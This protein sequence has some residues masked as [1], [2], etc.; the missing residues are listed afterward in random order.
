MPQVVRRY[1]PALSAACPN[2]GCRKRRFDLR[3]QFYCQFNRY[4]GLHSFAVGISDYHRMSPLFVAV[5]VTSLMSL[6]S[7]MIVPPLSIG[8]NIDLPMFFPIA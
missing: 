1:D 8:A 3:F 7:L 2:P 6:A 4:F 5:A